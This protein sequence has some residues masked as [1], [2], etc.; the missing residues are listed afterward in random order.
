MHSNIETLAPPQE[1]T[2]SPVIQ[3]GAGD[4]DFMSQ[5][6]DMSGTPLRR[7][8]F[9]QTCSNGCP[10]AGLMDLKPHAVWRSVQLGLRREVLASSAI[11]IC[12]GCHTCS[13]S[14]PM[15]LDLAAVMDALRS[16]ALAEGAPVA[17]PRILDFHRAVLESVAGRGRANKLEIMLRYKL[18][19]RDWF[20]DFNLGLRMLAKRKLEWAAPRVAGLQEIKRMFQPPWKGGRP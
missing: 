18:H 16:L 5:V 2:T 15:A 14:C 3:L 12:V 17:E 10:F 20:R 19:T 11:W 13:A 4:W 9:C 6:E 8:F 7:C 1:T